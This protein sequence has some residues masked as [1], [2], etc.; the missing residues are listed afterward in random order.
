[1]TIP[2]QMPGINF[3]T[4]TEEWA[5]AGM[6]GYCGLRAPEKGIPMER[7]YRPDSVIGTSVSPLG[8]AR[9]LQVQSQIILGYLSPLRAIYWPPLCMV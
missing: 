3:S 5:N 2:R 6:E 8:G 7:F 9:M 1:M 4:K